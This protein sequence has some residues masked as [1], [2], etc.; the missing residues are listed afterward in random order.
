MLEDMA[1]P[2]EG[3]LAVILSQ[4]L[5]TT[6]HKEADSDNKW[7]GPKFDELLGKLRQHVPAAG[8]TLSAEASHSSG[9]KSS[10]IVDS[11]CSHKDKGSAALPKTIVKPRAHVRS[12]AS[13]HGR[14]ENNSLRDASGQAHVNLERAEGQPFDAKK[15]WRKVAN[16]GRAVKTSK[17][18]DIL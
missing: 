9:D 13:Q 4:F 12:T 1:G 18:C 15:E 2:P 17:S 14:Q 10:T 7:E 11:K 5:Y 8:V 3:P 16:V 6:F